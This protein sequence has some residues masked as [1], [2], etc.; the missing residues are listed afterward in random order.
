M[1]AKTLV[2]LL[3]LQ[4]RHKVDNQ[5]LSFC[6]WCAIKNNKKQKKTICETSVA[7]FCISSIAWKQ[8]LIYIPFY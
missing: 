3:N 1:S 4:I 7:L 2:L 5:K 6:F 8:K